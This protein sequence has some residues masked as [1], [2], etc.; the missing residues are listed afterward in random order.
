MPKCTCGKVDLTHAEQTLYGRTHRLYGPC[1]HI[2]EPDQTQKESTKMEMTKYARKP[3]L[4]DAVEITKDNIEEVAKHVGDVRSKDDG[5]P[6]ILVDRRLVPNVTRV[7]IGFYMTKMGDNV[8]CYSK[9]VF[10]EQF[11]QNTDDIQKWV[12]FLGKK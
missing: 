2:N 4:V 9:K 10:N 7:Y 8:R 11:V 3:F 12:D 1:F 5:T 6:Y